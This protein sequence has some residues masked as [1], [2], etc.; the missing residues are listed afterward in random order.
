[1][2][3]L[4]FSGDDWTT[5]LTDHPRAPDAGAVVVLRWS[6]DI[7]AEGDW[8]AAFPRATTR[9]AAYKA[10]RTDWIDTELGWTGFEIVITDPGVG[11]KRF[12]MTCRSPSRSWPTVQPACE[13]I[14]R[15]VRLTETSSQ[16]ASTHSVSGS[17]V[18]D[19]A[20]P[21]GSL[22]PVTSGADLKNAAPSPYSSSP[23]F[24][25]LEGSDAGSPTL[26]SPANAEHP[27]GPA[28]S[29][30][31]IVALIAAAAAIVGLALLMIARAR[32]G[33]PDVPK[34]PSAVAGVTTAAIP[35][36]AAEANKPRF[37]TQCGTKI[38]TAGP[39]PNCGALE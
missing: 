35:A 12:S 28:L 11:G 21:P 24:T 25:G 9:L 4:D 1:M 31:L 34:V 22:R 36:L 19:A 5:V 13:R 10:L 37:C 16:V 29:R 18:A 32:K 30:T 7:S 2:A 20:S 23:A 26:V 17:S 33:R 15:S 38:V 14:V 27:A 3:P 8:P 6:N 39:C